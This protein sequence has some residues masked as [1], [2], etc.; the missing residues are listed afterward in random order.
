MLEKRKRTIN[1]KRGEEVAFHPGKTALAWRSTRKTTTKPQSKKV[2]V[3]LDFCDPLP[4]AMHTRPSCEAAPA[5]RPCSNRLHSRRKP[6][7]P[8]PSRTN[9]FN[10]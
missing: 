1:L 4:L 3:G 10:P 7:A 5:P 8:P 6:S 2:R 9:P